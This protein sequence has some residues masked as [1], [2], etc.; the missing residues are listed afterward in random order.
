MKKIFVLLVFSLFFIS[1]WNDEIE[2]VKNN[3]LED[4]KD[5]CYEPYSIWDIDKKSLNLNWVVISEW[6]KTVSSPMLWTVSYLNCEAWKTVYVNTLIAEIKPDFNNPNTINLSIQKWSI[7]A[8]KINLEAVKTSTISSFDIQISSLDKQIENLK[9]Q[10]QIS[11]NNIELTKKSS[12]LSK[13]DL[14]NQI[15][16]LKDSLDSLNNNLE[17]VNKSKKESLEKIE[18]SRENL[19]TSMKVLAEDNLL[20]IDEKYWITNTNKRLNDKYEDYL[21]AKNSTLKNEVKNDFKKLSLVLGEIETLDD[22]EISVFLWNLVLLD[23]KVRK[24]IKE[25]IINI[26]F[27]ENQIDVFYTLFLN[28]WN[29]VSNIKNSWDSLENSKSSTQTN[30]DTQI[31]NLKNQISTTKINLDNL[32][33][34]KLDSVDVWLDLQL[35]NL[36]SWLKSL[37]SNLE[38]LLSQKANLLSTKD[39]QLLNLDNQILQLNQSISSLNT[40]LSSR[41]IYSWINWIVKQKVTSIWNNVWVNAPICNII[42]NEKSTKIKITSPVVLEIWDK[43]IFEFNSEKYEI[44]IENALIYKDSI[45]QNY[46]YESNYLDRNYFKDWEI[47]ILSFD[48]NEE[49]LENKESDKEVVEIVSDSINMWKIKKIPVSYIKNRIEWN[50]VI[51]KTSTGI[52]ERE[53]ELWDINWKYVEVN[54]WLEWILEICKQ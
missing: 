43:L 33:I 41:S 46:V 22:L 49:A 45:T 48:N 51:V 8:Q 54:V 27:S 42:P 11:T 37:N 13:N 6:T 20:K 17:L 50:F 53:V 39:T 29:N 44:V 14:E 47:L 7:V 32:K 5:L 38:N 12:N 26:Y 10:I 19:Y 3:N 36:D 4:N 40:S 16:S 24:S 35:S 15:I 30:F 25:S 23:E 18:I 1:C 34:N 9:E 31:S 2:I 52:L 28:Y 21:W